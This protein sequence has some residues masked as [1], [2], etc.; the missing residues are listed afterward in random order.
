VTELPQGNSRIAWGER[1]L[2]R[3]NALVSGLPEGKQR[4]VPLAG[5]SRCLRALRPE[6]PGRP[7][8]AGLVVRLP[9]GVDVAAWPRR[10]PPD[11]ARRGHRVEALLAAS[12]RCL[13]ASPISAAPMAAAWPGSVGG[14]ATR[15]Q[16]SV[17]W[18]R[19]AAVARY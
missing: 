5:S 1:A 9:R 10:W 6:W 7:F 11:G 16:P 14:Q 2:P 12:V 15:A 17:V 8:G 18:P 13:A 4:A 3:G 19:V